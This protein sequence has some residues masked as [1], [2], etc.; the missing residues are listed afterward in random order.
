MIHS[1]SHRILRSMKL[2]I[3]HEIDYDVNKIRK[4]VNWDKI[5]SEFFNKI[6][7]E[8]NGNINSKS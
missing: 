8:K 3:V 5:F 1:L 4:T 2:R 6:V 7:K